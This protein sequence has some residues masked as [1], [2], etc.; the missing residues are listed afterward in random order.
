MSTLSLTLSLTLSFMLLSW[1]ILA[2]IAFLL[3]QAC[4][5]YPDYRKKAP[6]IHSTAIPQPSA[7]VSLPCIPIPPRLQPHHA[8][9]GDHTPLQVI[10]SPCR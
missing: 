1:Q 8:P 4:A 5:P 9:A 2:Y 3:H 6:Q 10:S 7:A